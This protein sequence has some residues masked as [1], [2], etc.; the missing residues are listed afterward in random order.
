M[1][2]IDNLKIDSLGLHG[3]LF[4]PSSR[5][6][7]GYQR[8]LLE[9]ISASGLQ[10]V[11]K[12]EDSL[13]IGKYRPKWLKDIIDSMKDL[14]IEDIASCGRIGKGRFNFIPFLR[15]KGMKGKFR[16]SLQ[17]HFDNIPRFI[18]S[19][20]LHCF[21][22]GSYTEIDMKIDN[23]IALDY[24]LK[25]LKSI[26]FEIVKRLGIVDEADNLEYYGS[27]KWYL[28]RLDLCVDHAV[29]V[30]MSL[31]ALERMSK[32]KLPGY[33]RVYTKEDYKVVFVP[34]KR[35]TSYRRLPLPTLNIY[36][37]STELV[38]VMNLQN[39]EIPEGMLE[40]GNVRVELQFY[41][42]GNT[43]NRRDMAQGVLKKI[44]RDVFEGRIEQRD[45][46]KVYT[47]YDIISEKI[48]GQK[49]KQFCNEI[50][51]NIKHLIMLNNGVISK[52]ALLKR[53][54]MTEDLIDDYMIVIKGLVKSG[55][56]KRQGHN[57]FA[58][59]LYYNSIGK[60]VDIYA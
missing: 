46:E 11:H 28:H 53:H 51:R 40:A 26:Q 29:G 49:L 59:E 60:E 47:Q 42:G 31:K 33:E 57:Y 12:I 6:L 52:A 54:Y 36:N 24:L 3:Y 30:E 19:G 45:L 9:R 14:G 56:L 22:T 44:R 58:D 32:L 41:H 34:V 8:E 13:I 55:R 48:G 23:S 20:S 1:N 50:D 37:K 39:D 43:G 25:Y 17:L 15:L 4:P 10:L 5:G 27:D 7:D 21:F 38:K 2:R 18:W 35:E 16:F